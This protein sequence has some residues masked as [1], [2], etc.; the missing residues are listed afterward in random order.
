MSTISARRRLIC[1]ALLPATLWVRPSLAGTPVDLLKEQARVS[2]H[3]SR[4]M[5]LGVT[6][7]GQRWVAVGER[8]IVVWSDDGGASWT[9]ATV[10]VSVT[11]TAVTFADAT[12]GW[13][14]GHDGAILHS[15]DGGKRWTLQFDG[16][17]ANAAV[18]AALEAGAQGAGSPD[19][20]QQAQALVADLKESVQFGP[21][22]PLLDVWFDDG[23][24]GWAV[25]AFGQLFR[26]ESAGREW[27]YAS[28]AL[29]NPDGLHFNRIQRFADARLVIAAEAGK[30]FQSRDEGK[31][32]HV[33]D[34]GYA[35][36][37]Y[38][39]LPGTSPAVLVAYGFAGHILRSEDD[40][41]TW[42]DLASPTRTSLIG[43]LRLDS[44]RLLVV[45][46][47][48]RVLASDDSGANWQLLRTET[49]RALG[50]VAGRVAQGRLPVAG[51][52]GVSS[53]PV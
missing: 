36:H 51:V 21:S 4:A 43:G 3:A 32:W 42:R 15:A 6:V 48:R 31:T 53:L 11:L 30:I 28:Q 38:G 35:G 50:G 26:T 14:V 27:T 12:L 44:G 20:R 19:A 7:V 10:P 24:R 13:A 16:V 49:G 1:S 47:V 22:R 23:R 45:D 34:T 8:G 40:G 2:S 25:G 5:L 37:L 52:G 9:Q 41:K 17:R 46:R 18:L 39:V 33:F 29:P